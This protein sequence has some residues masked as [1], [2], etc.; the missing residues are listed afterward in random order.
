[1]EKTS[2]GLDENVAGLLCYVLGW[3]SGLILI[4][5][6]PKNEFVRFHATQS[7]IIFSALTI[8]SFVFTCFPVIGFLLAGLTSAVGFILWIGE[9]SG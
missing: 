3:L 1:M 6:E 2:L 7:M 9:E 8:I 4:L 5:T